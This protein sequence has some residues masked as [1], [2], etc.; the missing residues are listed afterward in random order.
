VCF[1][2]KEEREGK[3]ERGRERERER[4]REGKRERG[5]D[6]GAWHS[7]SLPFKTDLIKY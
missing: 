4:E 1:L 5:R 7:T 2:K 3:R 6:E